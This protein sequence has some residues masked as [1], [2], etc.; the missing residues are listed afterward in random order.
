MFPMI[1]IKEDKVQPGDKRE[2]KEV[3]CSSSKKDNIFHV[4]FDTALYPQV[5][6]NF[7][8]A[9]TLHHSIVW[10]WE[11]PLLNCIVYI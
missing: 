6:S 10:L 8:C 5:I 9:I 1:K 3:N 11:V 2:N 4:A 7:W